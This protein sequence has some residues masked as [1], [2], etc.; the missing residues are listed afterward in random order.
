MKRFR[1]YLFLLSIGSFVIPSHLLQTNNND[2]LLEDFSGE[3]DEAEEENV[4]QDTPTEIRS[5]LT[6]KV[7]LE[8]RKRSQELHMQRVKVSSA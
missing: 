6:R 3:E 5:L 8:K 4:T 1:H 7:E 2:I